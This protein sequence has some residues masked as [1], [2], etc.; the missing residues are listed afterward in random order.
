[1]IYSSKEESSIIS[2]KH[3]NY[4]HQEFVGK[5][6]YSWSQSGSPTE[7]GSTGPR[8]RLGSAGDTVLDVTVK[9]IAWVTV[10]KS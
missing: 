6:N 4:T 7:P 8:R 5:D 3:R 2:L 9:N 1:M 10:P